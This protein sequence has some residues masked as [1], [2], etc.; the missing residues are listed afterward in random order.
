M[1]TALLAA[2]LVWTTLCL[3]GFTPGS[4]VAM[5]VLTA[6]LIAVHFGDPLRGL[7]AHPA[8]W[9]FLPFLAYGAANAAWITPTHWLG[10]TDWLNWAQAVA[11]FW[12]VLNGI[13]APVCRRALCIVLVSL[14]VASALLAGYQHFLRPSWIMLGRTQ[15]AQYLGRSSGPFGIPN[16]LGIFMALLI[17]PVGALAFTPGRRL[18]LRVSCTVA[19]A[20]LAAGFVLAISRGAWVAF[21]AA[22]AL[23]LLLAP[24][25]SYARRLGGAAA[26]VGTAIAAALVLYLSFPLMRVRVGQLVTDAGEKSRPI[27]WRGAWKIFEAH[28]VFGAGAGSYDALFE[29]YRPVGFRNDPVYAHCDYLNTLCDYGSVGFLLLFGGAGLVAWKCAGARGLAGAAFTGL[30]AFALHLFVDFDLKI[31]ALAMIFASVSALVTAE[32][33]PAVLGDRPRPS[34]LTGLSRAG[35]LVAAA[36][37]LWITFAWIVPKYRGDESRRAARE[38]IDTWAN[39]GAEIPRERQALAGVREGLSRAVALDPSNAQAWSDKAYA[40]SLWALANPGM[41]VDLGRD[42]EREAA[43]AVDLCPIVAEYWIRRSSGL[44]MQYRW[45]EG[46]DCLVHALL[47]APNR[48]DVWYYQAYHLSLA[49]NEVGPAL[50]ATD[51]CLRL[52]PGFLLAQVLRQ[53]LGGRPQR[54]P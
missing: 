29:A 16:S 18:S 13:E 27:V 50:A 40:D 30:L 51:I 19:L 12:V 45:V 23:R 8:G 24:G 2:N 36:A 1:R 26:V 10:W 37:W 47:L 5:A 43:R 14:G 20:A 42:V 31:P 6:L 39:T 28:P 21:I 53:R 54:P 15:S 46:G 25:R 3:G 41:T 33:W 7:R 48:A 49:P 11:V 17:P 9:L 52:D 4:R 38:K 44:D 32:A 22:L 34:A 35:V